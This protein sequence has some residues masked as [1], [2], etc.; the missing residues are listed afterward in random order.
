MDLA[1]LRFLHAQA[2]WHQVAEVDGVVAAFLLVFRDGANYPNSNFEWFAARYPRFLYVD[3]V[4]VDA[5]SHG[6]GLGAQ[7]YRELFDHARASG[8]PVVTCEF[9]VVPPNI[10]SAAF[11][12]RLG[13]QEVG[14]QWLD[15]GRKQVSMQAASV[16]GC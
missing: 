7:L 6:R 11:H 14:R 13:F 5:D 10:G 12:A 3:R 4:V 2:C 15:E 8:A 1:R 16:A 9:N